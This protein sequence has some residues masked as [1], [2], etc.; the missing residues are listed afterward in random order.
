MSKSCFPFY[1]DLSQLPRCFLSG[2]PRIP[3]EKPVVNDELS[4]LIDLVYKANPKTGLSE[5][6]L[7]ILASDSVN[8][9]IAAW[10]RSELLK[11]MDF[12]EKSIYQGQ[13]VD[14]ETIMSLTREVGESV[15]DYF[16]RVKNYSDSLKNE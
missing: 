11:P 5:S 16:F 1:K 2:T 8:P 14:D 9:E 6:D 3:C 13:Q 10:V 7:S 15:D 12:G 4:R